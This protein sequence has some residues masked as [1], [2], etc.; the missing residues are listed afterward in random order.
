MNWSY[1]YKHW[2]STIFLSP[3][4]FDVYNLVTEKSNRIVG[5][6]EVYPI[7]LIFGFLFS[8]PT[9]LLYSVVYYFFGN[10]NVNNSFSKLILITLAVIGIFI[11]FYLTFNNRETE[12]SIAYA[13]TS[14][15]TGLF[16]TLNFNKP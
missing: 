14:I 1:L 16:F 12:I 9:Y 6:V 13:I 3:I 7:T 4:V 15:T 11:S 5:L 2:F 8:I 10:K